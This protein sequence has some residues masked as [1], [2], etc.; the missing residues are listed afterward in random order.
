MEKGQEYLKEALTSNWYAKKANSF[1]CNIYKI[2]KNMYNGI[3]WIEKQ[4]ISTWI[5]LEDE[6]NTLA[7]QFNYIH[8]ALWW[9]SP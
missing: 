6:T 5:S 4:T 2:K 8:R 3:V 9:I 1:L 7:S